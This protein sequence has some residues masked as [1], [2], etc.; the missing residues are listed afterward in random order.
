MNSLVTLYN[1]LL[2]SV[3]MFYIIY[4][5]NED[6]DFDRVGNYLIPVLVFGLFSPLISILLSELKSGMKI[7]LN[8]IALVLTIAICL[9]HDVFKALVFGI[10]S[11][12]MVGFG[13]LFIA[14]FYI[15]PL[16][17]AV[18][19]Y[20]SSPF[21]I[22]IGHIIVF[23]VSY[24]FVKLL[25]EKIKRIV[26]YVHAKRYELMV[27]L[28]IELL[29]LGLMIGLS[30][31]YYVRYL[32]NESINSANEYIFSNMFILIIAL[33]VIFG[34]TL[35]LLNSLIA[36]K[37]SLKKYISIY[38]F[39]YLTGTYNRRAGIDFLKEQLTI[40]KR[41]N[42]SITVCY[43]DIDNLKEINDKYGHRE[44]DKL[45]VAIID[46]IKLNIRE[47]D[48]IMRIGGDEFV[49]IFPDSN[50][51]QAEIIMKRITEK[52][53]EVKVKADEN[54]V[55][56]FSY[57]LAEYARGGPIETVESLL[58]K[59]DQQMYKYKKLHSRTTNA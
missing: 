54:F 58:D 37:L 53:K 12:L 15:F 11:S 10:L 34:A 8:L 51:Y 49:I 30:L 18:D 31:N 48:R 24:F 20:L 3:N 7:V 39:D 17:I 56:S 6:D 55:A 13:D 9:K 33:L 14:I 46:V 1:G 25:G 47:S 35:Y 45:I 52:L 36:S 5:L 26:N 32:K 21:H 28:S 50:I 27:V 57:G 44:G 40:S 16:N 4:R 43:M 41:K 22:T 23:S 29:A 42:I 2:T 19:D 38:N 59:A